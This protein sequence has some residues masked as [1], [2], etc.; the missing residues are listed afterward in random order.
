MN[1]STESKVVI[2]DGK[3]YRETITVEHEDIRDI[4]DHLVSLQSRLEDIRKEEKEIIKQI[5]EIG[6]II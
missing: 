4:T 6:K 5:E 2:K 1:K 3:V